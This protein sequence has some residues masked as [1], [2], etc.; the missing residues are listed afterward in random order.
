MR[1]CDGLVGGRG[2]ERGVRV[3]EGGRERE[4]EGKR[5]RYY[6]MEEGEEEKEN[7][8]MQVFISISMLPNDTFHVG[9]QRRQ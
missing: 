7:R 5:E 2:I 6:M 8:F 9:S 1:Y 4:R 3:R